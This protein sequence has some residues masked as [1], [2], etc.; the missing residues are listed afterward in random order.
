MTS[1]QRRPSL[2]FDS[3]EDAVVSKEDDEQG[4]R[5]LEDGKL[6][7]GMDPA[8]LSID[9][10]DMMSLSTSF[11]KQMLL[12]S[13]MYLEAINDGEKQSMVLEEFS[14]HG[15]HCSKPVPSDASNLHLEDLCEAENPFEHIV[16]M[17]TKYILASLQDSRSNIKNDISKWFLYPK[18]LPKFWKFSHDKRLQSSDSVN[19][20]E[21]SVSTDY[22]K[23]GYYFPTITE[24]QYLKEDY[25]GPAKRLGNVHY[26]GEFF[27]LGHYLKEFENHMTQFS[28]YPLCGE[29]VGI[30]SFDE[31][32]EDFEFVLKTL[33]RP[34]L[35]Q[36]A[37]RRMNYLLDKFE[38][39]Q[40]LNSKAE[41]L[42]NKRVPLRDFYNARKVDRDLLFSGFITQRQLSEFIWEKLNL[43]PHRVVY[44]SQYGETFTLQ[45]IFEKTCSPTEPLDIGLKIINDEFL[46]WYKE[47]YLVRSHIIPPKIAPNSLK[48]KELRFFLLAKTFLEIENYIDGEYMAEIFIKYCIHTLEKSKYQLAQISVDF[49]FYD[50]GETSWWSKFAHWII[51]W[52]IVS[53]NIR[54][55]VQISRCYSKLFSSG[56]VQNFQ[57]F[58]DLIFQPLF[59]NES[60]TNI[61]LQFFLSNVCCI[62]LI[63]SQFDD[64]LWKSFPGTDTKPIE[65]T[66]SDN[67]TIS[68]YMYYTY[69]TLT[70]MNNIRQCKY[71][72]TISLRSS[73][74][75][76]A[77]RTSQAG[78][79]S[80]FSDRVE[81]LVCNLLLCEAGLVLAEPLFD[82]PSMLP[83]L[84]YL[85]QIPIVVA[86]LSSVSSTATQTHQNDIASILGHE[87]HTTTRDIT[88]INQSTY[89]K[90]PFMDFF[91]V[92]MKISLSSISVLFN[93]SYT[94]EPIIE[95]YSVAASIYLLNAAD[96]CEFSRN[97]VLCS[98]YE[99]FYK[100]HW[101]G[102]E[103]INTPFFRENVG[104]V[105]TW[106]DKESD[107]SE[108]HNVPMIRRKYRKETLDQEWSFIKEQFELD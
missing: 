2:L 70:K 66:N 76:L 78:T 37:Q 15:S 12:G 87:S 28:T 43:E 51:K 82:S 8:K 5:I 64:Y 25:L 67:P 27:E 21:Q 6:K 20:N 101:I 75:P 24:D 96:L 16:N 3:Y 61:E 22:Q 68:H 11:D 74:S 7:I 50:K 71:L 58:L 104:F 49:Q 108:R 9:D 42:E 29:L 23:K 17:R 77:N 19:N 56:K 93:S 40:L 13:P 73:C 89:V 79:T 26:T 55:N 81:S 65:W 92:G 52:K 85:C 84:F 32:R 83:Y 86:P 94:S 35:S 14:K 63:V 44:R 57:E 69:L 33:Q 102:V 34:T 91:K 95:E 107:T 10:M 36:I 45:E 103:T 72:N 4:R 106:Y 99:G 105:N 80:N 38:L 97:S 90:N 59:E 30:P 60:N 31:F 46:E 54:W 39:F 48:G 98:G 100:A 62:D 88:E 1:V 41:I 18:P 47:V 53:H